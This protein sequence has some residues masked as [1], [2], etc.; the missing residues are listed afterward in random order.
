M[1]APEPAVHPLIK[2]LTFVV[3]G[4]FAIYGPWAIFIAFV[5]GTLPIIGIRL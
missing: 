3:V 4:A 1:E 5:G 2:A